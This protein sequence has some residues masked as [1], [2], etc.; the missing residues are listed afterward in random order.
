VLGRDYVLPVVIRHPRC[1]VENR[2]RVR[3][4]RHLTTVRTGTASHDRHDRL[5]H[6]FRCDCL[7]RQRL[8]QGRPAFARQGNEKV[9]DAYVRVTKSASLVLREHN[10]AAR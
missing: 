5:T 3:C 8:R 10:D 6:L 4:E 7:L 9:L 2:F 1:S